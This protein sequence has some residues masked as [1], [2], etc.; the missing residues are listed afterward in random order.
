VPQ[1]YLLQLA[2]EQAKWLTARQTIV[3]SNIVNADT[4]DYKAKD[5]QPFSQVLDQTGVTM[6]S[7]HSDDIDPGD[8]NFTP[9][10]EV[11]EDS[12]N[13]DLSGNSVDLQQELIKEGDIERSYTLNTNISRIFHQMILSALK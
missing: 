4:P 12:S 13:A 11:E 3:A 10:R 9:A 6:V 8:T 7:T 2:S 1:V 5:I